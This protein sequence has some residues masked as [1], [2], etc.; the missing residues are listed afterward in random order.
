M[1]YVYVLKSQKDN[2]EKVYFTYNGPATSA[3][4]MS[5]EQGKMSDSVRQSWIEKG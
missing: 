5:E 4:L 1:F 3:E 2:Y